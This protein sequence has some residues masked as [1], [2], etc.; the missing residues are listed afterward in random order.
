M[1]TRTPNAE[2]GGLK[3]GEASLL[4]LNKL[5]KEWYNWTMKAGKKP[6]F[7]KK[8]VAYYVIGEEKW[9]YADSLEAI[10]KKV[11]KLYLDSDGQANDVF[12][13]GTLTE[14]PPKA[15]PPNS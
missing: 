7:L 9:K 8:R 5:H 14:K 15:A 1:G 3:V 12:H 6:A 13:S 2:F 10:T 4:D 11:Q